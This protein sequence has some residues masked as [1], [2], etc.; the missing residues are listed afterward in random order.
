MQVDSPDKIR[1]IAVAGHND[2]GKTTLVS[3][4]STRAESPPGCTGSRT[5]TPSPTSTTRRP[6]ADLDRARGLLRPLAT[7]QDQ[8]HRL[9]RIRHLLHRD[10]GR[11]CA[12]PTPLLLAIN[13]VA[14]RRGQHRAGV[15][16]RGRDRPAGHGHTSP[17]W[18]ASGPT[19]T[20]PSKG[21][22]S[23]SAAWCCP[24][25]SPSAAR[26]ASPASSTWYARRPSTSPATATA[27]RSRPR[28]PPGS[29]AASPSRRAPAR[30]GGRR[31][32]RQ[33][34]GRLLREA[35]PWRRRTSS[36]ACGGPCARR[37][38]FP[39]TV[40]AGSARHRLRGA[41][42]RLPRRSPLPRR[43]RALPGD[44]PGRR[45]DGAHRRPRRRRSA[46]LVFKTLSDPFTGKISILRVVSGTLR[47]D[48]DGLQPARRGA[49]AA[50][51][52][53]GA[54]GQDRGPTCRS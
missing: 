32:R 12:P 54:S 53:A 38:I 45:G 14:G 51:P 41:P 26:P 10:Q 42:R 21:C 18:T 25:R 23:A 35:A 47:S 33:A 46:A 6:N 2:T 17:R 24:S 22:T 30:R 50:R 43:P 5:A 4:L 39:L 20:A 8:P 11:A 52:P 37:Q 7:A 40:S 48:S 19:S 9:S 36:R 29:P 34:H 3:A 27:R 31:D 16:L 28:S 13:G 44:E 15:E 49:R 1:N